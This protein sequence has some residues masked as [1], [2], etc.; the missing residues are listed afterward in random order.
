M[1]TKKALLANKSK[2]CFLS[3][4]GGVK[5]N[6]PGKVKMIKSSAVNIWKEFLIDIFLKP[7]A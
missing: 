5:H 3:C 7:A 2:K 1:E 6:K 4:M